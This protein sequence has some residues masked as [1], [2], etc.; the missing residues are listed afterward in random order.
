MGADRYSQLVLCNP[1]WISTD[2]ST[3]LL[4]YDYF[5]TLDLEFELFWKRKLTSA[6]V[7]FILI[8]YIAIARVL[9]SILG[10][11]SIWTDPVRP[12]YHANEWHRL[13]DHTRGITLL[14]NGTLA[15]RIMLD[16]SR[17]LQ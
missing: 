5:L 14:P 16:L 10:Y 3:A 15:W 12:H 7:L 2:V 11:I 4:A 8:R 1:V 9:L 17:Q 6:S 13:T